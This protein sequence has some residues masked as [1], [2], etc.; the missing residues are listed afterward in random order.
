[1]FGLFASF[2]SYLVEASG[3]VYAVLVVGVVILTASI[4]Y[5]VL[6][7]LLKLL[8]VPLGSAGKE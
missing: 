5:L 8:K 6:Q 4:L 1:M 3:P 2:F 7:L